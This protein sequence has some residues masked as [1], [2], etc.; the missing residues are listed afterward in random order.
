MCIRDRQKPELG[1]D[2]DPRVKAR[3]QREGGERR[4]H[5]IPRN[6]KL[7]RLRPRVVI[8]DVYKRQAENRSRRLFSKN[9]A[10]C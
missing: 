2:G 5:K 8:P 7:E 10:L 3:L 1:A 6:Q 9:T 4:G